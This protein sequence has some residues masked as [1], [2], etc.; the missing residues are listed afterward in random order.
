MALAACLA[1]FLTF[2]INATHQIALKAEEILHYSNVTTENLLTTPS[3]K[4]NTNEAYKLNHKEW[5]YKASPQT[6]E[7]Y[8]EISDIL[9]APDGV[10]RNMTVIN[11]QFP[12]PMVECNSG[13]TIKVTVKNS[14]KKPTA[15][16]FHGLLFK[17]A[18]YYDGA[19]SINQ[20]EIPVNYTYTYEFKI[21]ENQWGTYWYHS[22]YST[23]YA[24]GVLGPVV[25]HSQKEHDLIGDQ[26]DEEV[27]V[28]MQDH[29]HD[30]ADSYLEEYL[31][32]ENENDEPT[33]DNGLIQ[34]SNVFDYKE[35]FPRPYDEDL[36]AHHMF[37]F[38]PDKTYRVRLINCGIFA[39]MDFTIDQ[40]PLTVIEADGTNVKPVTVETINIAVA[41]RYSVLITTNATTANNLFWMQAKI[42]EYCFGHMNPVLNTAIRAI[43]AYGDDTKSESNVSVFNSMKHHLT[44]L[45]KATSVEYQY[46]KDPKCV[47]FDEKLL[48]PLIPDPAPENYNQHY[49]TDVSFMIGGHELDRGYFNLTSY[50]PLNTATL[51]EQIQ[52]T[53]ESLT[54]TG[55]TIPWADQF[56]INVNEKGSVIDLLVN[57]LDDGAHPFHLHGYKFWILRATSGNFKFKY[58]NEIDA[59]KEYI[60]RDTIN[61][62]GYGY[63]LIRFVADNPGVWPFHCH[64]GW[65]MEAG[66][67]MQ[68][69]V[70]PQ[71]Y[72]KWDFPPQWK[73]ICEM[74][75]A[76]LQ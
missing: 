71:E 22:H 70:L 17:N 10:W 63:A 26:Y 36:S 50:K 48:H 65:H 69:N 6:R 12:G 74:K 31:A 64:I 4:L 41:Q 60:K 39:D 53:D 23:Q 20:C 3:W 52:N 7:Y 47:E 45:I 68:F 72:K 55:L 8:F 42:N 24:D 43:V 2:Q 30:T 58:Y 21:D 25:I 59:K 56:I 27:V 35:D 14:G 13:D 38:K 28:L 37:K 75:K 61:I 33:P 18:N 51:Y 46:Y 49:R 66:L 5:D 9:A 54:T 73:E 29:Y 67:L 34:G 76:L 19:T 32:P 15:I 11:G 40:H 62:P 57:N 1:V 44:N 16:H